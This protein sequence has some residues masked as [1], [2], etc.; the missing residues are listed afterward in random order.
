MSE[1]SKLYAYTLAPPNICSGHFQIVLFLLETYNEIRLIF[2]GNDHDS[3][4]SKMFSVAG[5]TGS[6]RLKG[7]ATLMITMFYMKDLNKP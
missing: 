1:I 7:T 5:V 6:F 4:S 2:R 3:F